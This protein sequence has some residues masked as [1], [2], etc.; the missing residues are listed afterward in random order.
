MMARRDPL[1]GMTRNEIIMRG[2]QCSL[3]DDL[4][5][6]MGG[7]LILAVALEAEYDEI[8]V[9]FLTKCREREEHETALRLIDETLANAALS[10]MISAA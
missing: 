2:K 6:R 4:T 8:V 3:S 1:E 5:M 10:I 7:I 9:A